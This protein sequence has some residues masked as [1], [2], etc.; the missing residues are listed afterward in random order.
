M[1]THLT[2]SRAYPVPV[3]Q[4]FD[5][6][7]STPLPELFRHRYGPLP[8]IR[9]VTGFT[10]PWATA[11]Q[12]RRITLSDGGTLLESLTEVARPTRFAYRISEIT[13]ALKPMVGGI[14]GAWSFE[15]AGTG[16]RV[17]WT[18][19][20]EPASTASGY[21]M[22]VFGKLWDGYARQALENLEGLLLR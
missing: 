11:G 7:L 5:A 13:G 14:D 21:L 18:W 17:T 20:V 3:E 1:G 6:V 22:P 9:S 4:A 16:V 15:P 8:P 12:T 2:A 19:D 10:E